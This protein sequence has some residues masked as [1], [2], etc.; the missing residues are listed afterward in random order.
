MTSL[1]MLLAV[2]LPL[3]LLV[4]KY[5]IRAPSATAANITVGTTI[6]QQLEHLPVAGLRSML[7]TVVQEFELPSL[8]QQR[9]D[10]LATEATYARSAWRQQLALQ[11]EGFEA[12]VEAGLLENISPLVSDAQ[13][14]DQ[15]AQLQGSVNR[16]FK[17]SWLP[18]LLGIGV[19]VAVFLIFYCVGV[20]LNQAVGDMN[21]LQAR[22]LCQTLHA[23]SYRLTR[24]MK[25]QGDFLIILISSLQP[26]HNLGNLKTLGWLINNAGGMSG[27]S[28][29]GTPNTTHSITPELPVSQ[30]TMLNSMELYA[31]STLFAQTLGTF[32]VL[33][34]EG[35]TQPL[36]L[37]L[38]LILTQIY[39]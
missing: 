17:E 30:W 13:H 23:D 22:S 3:W 18:L 15:G 4:L 8:H 7:C 12:Q 21:A 39:T 5:A 31:A 9:V 16:K 1:V 28:S 29:S 32:A 36:T 38:T 27:G 10:V 11:A 26:I 34:N 19:P 33:L 2:I 37:T 35:L 14:L 25:R 20:A 6:V 24:L